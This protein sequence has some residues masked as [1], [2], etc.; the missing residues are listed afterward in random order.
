ML[1]AVDVG[2]T[3]TVLGLYR[4]D[5]LVDSF[6]LAT[7]RSRTGDEL[8]VTLSALLDL[9][10]VDGQEHARSLDRRSGRLGSL[11]G[12]SSSPESDSPIRSARASAVSLGSSP[13]PRSSSTVTS[14]D[15]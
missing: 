14:L 11:Y 10:D 6:R 15:V 8:A 1:L 5:D 3:Q 7:D 13:S 4:E 12:V 2:N 9:E